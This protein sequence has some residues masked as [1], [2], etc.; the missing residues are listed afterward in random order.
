M[1]TVLVSE[2]AIPASPPRA[3]RSWPTPRRLLT[4]GTLAVLLS[5]GLGTLIATSATGA[6]T[7]VNV[8]GEQA[9]P[10]V[11]VTTDLYF[12]LSDLDAQAANALL[13]GTSPAMAS[14][15]T[16]ALKLYEQRRTQAD[17][18]LQQAAADGGSDLV[19]QQGVRTALNQ[20]GLYESLVSQALL[21]NQQGA[22]PAGRP[23]AATLAQYRQATDLMQ[24]VLTGVQK[25]TDH[26]HTILGDTYAQ[27]S[28]DSAS[29]QVWIG[30]LGGLLVL[31]LVAIQV[32]LWLRQRRKLNPALLGATV[33]ALLV[34]VLGVAALGSEAASL[35]TAKQDAFDS[36]VA[37]AQARAV[38]YDANADESRYLV[39]P[40]RAAQYQQAFETKIQSLAS[41]PSVGL[42]RYEPALST[43]MDNYRKNN[44]DVGFGGYFGKELNNVTFAGEGQAA[45]H[46]IAAFQTYLTDDQHLRAFNTSGNLSGAIQFDISTAPG[47]SDYAF[48]AYDSALVELIGINQNAFT[49]SIGQAQSALAGWTLLVPG[50][51][52]LLILGLTALGLWP[53]IAEYR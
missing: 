32:Q 28:A 27:D 46:T 5:A 21:V 40:Q 14:E 38:S 45:Q 39:D 9:A 53:R 31:V 25:L 30:V 6:G 1:S 19:V 17:T 35:R 4:L 50:I 44:A 48:N 7:E 18:D 24:T 49:A 42:A 20:L 2:P 13:V 41:F 12:A 3:R 33:V 10:Q 29:T 16:A 22:D 43:A 23:S 37:L 8:I 36:I 51:A 47:N 52:A 11:R 15:R 34:T 26:N